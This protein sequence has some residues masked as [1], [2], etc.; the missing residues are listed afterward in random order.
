MPL[1]DPAGPFPRALGRGAMTGQQTAPAAPGQNLHPWQP[2]ERCVVVGSGG[3][4]SFGWKA[5][6]LGDVWVAAGVGEEVR[7]ALC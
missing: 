6:G 4:E 1:L 2:S 7:L 3:V 5:H